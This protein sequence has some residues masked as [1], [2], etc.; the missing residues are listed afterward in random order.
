MYYSAVL[1]GEYQ[2]VHESF[3]AQ[4]TSIRFENLNSVA[5]CYAITAVDS[6]QNESA[7]SERLCVDNCPVYELPNVI[8]PGGDGENDILRPFPYRYVESIDLKIYNRWGNLV[9]ETTNPDVN[10]DGKYS[11]NNRALNSGVYFYTCIVNEI[12]LNGIV[13]RNLSGSI[14][15]LNQDGPASP[16]Q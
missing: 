4:D 11:L 15:I 14:S 13:P 5:G 10:W 16:N 7:F 1:G 9:F 3:S 6:F 12:R 8:T 2:L